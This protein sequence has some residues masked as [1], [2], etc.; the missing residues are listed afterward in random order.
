[1]NLNSDVC[2]EVH[3]E[4]LEKDNIMALFR[5]YDLILDGSDNF[6]T[7]FLVADAAWL[8]GLSLI[9]I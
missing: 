1:M 2:L 6:P 8:L 5:Q 9:H 7:R 4:R 3:P